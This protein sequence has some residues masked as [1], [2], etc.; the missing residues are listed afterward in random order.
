MTFR[1]NHV[2]ISFS[3][4]NAES[5]TRNCSMMHNYSVNMMSR[6]Y[7]AVGTLESLL[8]YAMLHVR[9][10]AELGRQ[11]TDQNLMLTQCQGGVSHFVRSYNC[12]LDRE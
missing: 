9:R 4:F 5:P 11:I 3:L 7:C 8:I 2:V 12:G 1:L 10:N 6:S